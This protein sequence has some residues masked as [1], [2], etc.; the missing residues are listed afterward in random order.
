MG[1]FSKNTKLLE[2][3]QLEEIQ[4]AL[5]S[6]LQEVKSLERLQKELKIED[7]LTLDAN[8]ISD[9]IKS[10]IKELQEYINKII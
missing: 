7:H 1:I 4:F 10:R 2:V 3:K 6:A 5:S 9:D 8:M